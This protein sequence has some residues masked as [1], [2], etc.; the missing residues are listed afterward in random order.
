[1]TVALMVIT[2]GRRECLQATMRSLWFDAQLGLE[3]F[4]RHVIV[5]DSLD[6]E[7]TAWLDDVFAPVFTILHPTEGK[8]GFAGA[9]RAGWDEIGESCDHITHLEDDFTFNEPVPLERMVAVLKARPDLAQ[10]VLKRQ[11]WNEEERAAGGIVE[12]HPDDFTETVIEGETLTTHRRFFSTNVC[13]Y[14]TRLCR[15]GWP[16]VPRSE[17]I[18]THLLL[19]DPMLKFAFWGGKFDPPRI[20]HIGRERVGSGY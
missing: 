5:N 10:I 12:L 4:A 9:I 1:M 8:R 14:P 11:A 13:V 19:R 7:F 17:G 15:V 20:E 2:D 16:Q 18:F 3:R 6:A